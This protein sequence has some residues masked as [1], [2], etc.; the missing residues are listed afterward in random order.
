MARAQLMDAIDGAIAALEE[1]KRALEDETPETGYSAPP[2]PPAPAP[3]PA[4]TPAGGKFCIKCGAQLNPGD[5]FY[6]KCGTR[7]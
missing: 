3:A 7:I 1:L 4:P 5:K 2:V 6:T